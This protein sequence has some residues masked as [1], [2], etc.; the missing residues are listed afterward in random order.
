MTA[1]V[2]YDDIINRVGGGF[3]LSQPFTDFIPATTANTLGNG[4]SLQRLGVTKDTPSLPSGVTAFMLTQVTASVGVS[5]GVLGTLM[6][7]QLINLGSLNIGTNVFT[8]GSAMPTVTEL[9]SSRQV[10]G[11]VFVEVTT[12]LTGTP[13]TLTITYQDQDGNASETTS[14]Q[15]MAASVVKSSG[16]IV[17]NSNDW[18]VIDISA[19]ARS[20]GTSPAGVIKFWGI[21][22]IGMIPLVNTTNMQGV[23]NLLTASFNPIRLGAAATVGAFLLASTASV[24]MT[25]SLFFVGDS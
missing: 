8:D 9:G 25:G 19:A 20:G 13:G 2:A 21:I 23:E 1:I 16:W 3:T 11:P 4:T 22:P 18:G 7:A 6:V 24:A 5:G 12:A 17:L 14:A 10:A 15:T